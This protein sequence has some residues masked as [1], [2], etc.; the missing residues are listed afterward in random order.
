MKS[1]HVVSSVFLCLVFLRVPLFAAESIA[2]SPVPEPAA[3]SKEQKKSEVP[4]FEAPKTD[5]PK[6]EAA[7]DASPPPPKVPKETKDAKDEKSAKD[8]K[9]TKDSKPEPHPPAAKGKPEGKSEGAKEGAKDGAKKESS[10]ADKSAGQEPEARPQKTESLPLKRPLGSTILTVKLALVADPALFPY[11]IEVTMDGDKAVL[12]GKVATE[13]EKIRA[14][15]VAQ[16]VETVGGVVNKLEVV[17]DLGGMLV[18][19]HD[20]AI[21]QYVKDRFARSETLKAAGFEVKCEQGVIYLSGTV[22][23]QVFALEAAQAARQV[24]GVRA[25]DTTHVQLSG[26]GKE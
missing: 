20:Q 3:P 16:H 24:P 7:S 19:R 8:P 25:V 17:K 10:P 9:E 18:K 21:L 4:K 13:D 5:A 22:R 26:E 14:A 1:R 2:P 12:S 23:F 11:E 6:P 15:E